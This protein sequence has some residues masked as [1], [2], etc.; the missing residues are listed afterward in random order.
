MQWHKRSLVT[1][2]VLQRTVSKNW[3]TSAVEKGRR[4]TIRSKQR[5]GQKD[6]IFYWVNCKFS[7]FL[8]FKIQFNMPWKFGFP[9]I[10]R[11]CKTNISS[12]G[13]LIYEIGRASKYD[14]TYVICPHSTYLHC[15]KSNT[16]IINQTSTTEFIINFQGSVILINSAKFEKYKF[17]WY[18][19]YVQPASNSKWL[20]MI[21]IT[22]RLMSTKMY[23][24]QTHQ[25]H[26]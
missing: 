17:A 11:F 1:F 22:V 19:R 14:N 10:W 5:E 20:I 18:K 24:G 6:S 7:I 2:K 23:L 3:K 25:H 8:I 9:L 26:Y 16:F 13:K 4:N 12:L 21:Q 15:V